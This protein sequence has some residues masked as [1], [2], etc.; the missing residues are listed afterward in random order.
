MEIKRVLLLLAAATVLAGPFEAAHAQTVTINTKDG[1]TVPTQ[2]IRRDGNT[3]M[4]RIQTADGNVG[5]VGYDVSA[6]AKIVFPDAPQIKTATDLLH[7]GRA[8]E[9]FKQLAPITAYYFPFRDVP[10]NLWPQLAILEVDALERLGRD[11]DADALVAN[12]T[13][14][15]LASPD[16]LRSVKVRQGQ[17]MEHKAATPDDQKQVL[18][19]L[20][21]IVTDPAAEPQAVA[22]GWIN[23][24]AAH[25]A[26]R[27]FK[28]ALLAYLHIPLYTPDRAN[29]MSQA[30]LGSAIAFVGVND[31]ERA[32]AAL[33]TLID[34]YPTAPE[35]SEAKNRL[36]GLGSGAP[37][38][39]PAG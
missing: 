6:I 32:R 4:A 19:F 28:P 22:V 7:E 34:K 30:L 31:Q 21:P 14:L 5:E 2:G 20:E 16:M 24:G 33:K 9:A 1:Q 38:T 29:L 25:L 23:V 27:E 35:V 8:D 11:A 39:A 10:G 13:K 17:A 36:Q 15:G 37:K 3:I 18:A 12:L 26:L